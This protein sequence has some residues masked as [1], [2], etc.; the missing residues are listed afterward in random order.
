MKYNQNEKKLSLLK[1]EKQLSIFL[2]DILDYKNSE[3][4]QTK[5][6]LNESKKSHNMTN[7]KLFDTQQQNEFLKDL[8]SILDTKVKF[9]ERTS[10]RTTKIID[11]NPKNNSNRMF[12]DQQLPLLSIMSNIKSLKHDLNK[13]INLDWINDFK[14]LSDSVLLAKLQVEEIIDF[15]EKELLV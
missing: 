4:T 8:R 14:K 12:S 5:I 9:L 10:D 13:E 6:E 7:A 1:E 2:S 11:D 15:T 3:L